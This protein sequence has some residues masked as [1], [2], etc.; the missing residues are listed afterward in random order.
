MSK[1]TKSTQPA[2][3][4]LTNVISQLSHRLLLEKAD[5]HQQTEEKMSVHEP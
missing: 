2:N 5:T 1:H 4:Y 3:E